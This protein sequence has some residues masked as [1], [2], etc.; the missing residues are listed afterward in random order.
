E[1]LQTG[2]SGQ[3]YIGWVRAAAVSEDSRSPRRN[4]V[5][6]WRGRFLEQIGGTAPGCSN[7]LWESGFGQTGL[8]RLAGLSIDSGLL[9]ARADPGGKNIRNC[10]QSSGTLAFTA[11]P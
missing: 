5:C 11:T 8:G 9:P 4:R 7:H 1:I 6:R 3:E 2:I 10:R